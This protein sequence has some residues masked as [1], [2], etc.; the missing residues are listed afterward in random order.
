MNKKTFIFKGKE[1]SYDYAWFGNTF[2][3]NFGD[4]DKDF[5]DSDGDEYF[6]HC[7][8]CAEPNC[9]HVDPFCFGIW[10]EHDSTEAGY[11]ELTEEEREYIKEFMFELMYVNKL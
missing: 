8:Y 7:Q 5:V 9:G 10:W 6:I 3:F 4:G 2:S 11:D 1:T